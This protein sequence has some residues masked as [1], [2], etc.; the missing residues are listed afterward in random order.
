MN[1]EKYQPFFENTRRALLDARNEEGVWCGHLSSSPL[2]T[3]VAVFALYSVDA[4]KYQPF[5][6]N[7]LKWLAEHQQGDGSWGDA[8]TLDPGNLSTTLLCYCVFF[9]VDSGENVE[10]IART[11]HWI[12]QHAGSLRPGDLA[13]AVYAVYGKDRTFAVPILTMCALAGVLG[14]DGWSY[15]RPLPFEL[16]VLPRSLFRWLRLTVVSYALPALIAI[17]QV[18]F[19]YDPPRNL[20]ARF[21]R[22]LTLKKTL[23]ILTGLQPSNGG[24]LEAAPLT[25]FVTMSL[26]A[27][28]YKDHP[29]VQKGVEFLVQSVREDGSWPI[30]TNL[31]TWL[32]SLAI[33]ALRPDLDETVFSEQEKIHLTE[34]YLKQQFNQVHPFTGAKPGGWAWTNLPGSVPDADDTAGAL[35]ALYR[36]GVRNERVLAAAE[37]GVQWLLDLQNGDGGIPTFCRG[38]GRLEFDRS[39]PDLT[40]HAISAWLA[41]RE[42]LSVKIQVRIDKAMDRA[43]HYLKISQKSDG[44]WL[45]LWFGNPFTEEKKNP[46]YGTSKAVNVISK[47]RMCNGLI[48]QMKRNGI[49]YLLKSQNSDG[50]WGAQKNARSTIEETAMSLN[51]I[52]SANIKEDSKIAEKIE[53]R[54][55][56]W[57]VNRTEKGCIFRSSP[58]GLYFAKLWYSEVLYPLI[59]SGPLYIRTNS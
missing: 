8:E 45:P 48:E 43:I 25:A 32:T 46:V 56:D 51:A 58:V 4:R 40:A 53:E 11:Q 54:G 35:V 38:W 19:Y 18:K 50:G 9:A 16:A 27:M 37:K 30:D 12:E 1:K 3:A 52:Q 22:R 21:L 36:L 34:W 26:A 23:K 42:L 49:E 13:E 10:R 7:G 15:V 59:L 20:L 29:V 41:W 57:L 55:L 5:I 33:E 31:S 2:A 44:S 47:L 39:C 24:F 6:Q 28:E 17:G 14:P